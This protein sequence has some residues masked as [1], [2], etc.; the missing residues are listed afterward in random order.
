MLKWPDQN[1]G[2]D[3]GL[4]LRVTNSKCILFMMDD[5]G[6]SINETFA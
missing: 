3:P 1:P 5:M 6:F 2:L 4:R